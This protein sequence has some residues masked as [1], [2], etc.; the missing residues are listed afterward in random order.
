VGDHCEAGVCQ[1]GFLFCDDKN[2]CT[3]DS[4]DPIKS[5]VYEPLDCNDDNACT[6]DSC[7][8]SEGCANAVDDCDDNNKCTYDF[9]D[10]SLGC[11]YKEKDCE[12]DNDV[13]TIVVCQPQTGKC[14]STSLDCDDQ[15]ACTTESCDPSTG[16][17]SEPLDCD[18]NNDCTVDSC[19]PED[20]CVNAVKGK[21]CSAATDCD[22]DNACTD[23]SCGA[24]GVCENV[25]ISCDDNNECTAASCDPTKG[26]QSV[27][28]E[29]QAC[30]P[31]DPC[32]PVGTCSG[33]GVCAPTENNCPAGTQDDPA[34]SCLQLK[35]SGKGSASGV[36][37]L[38]V[39]PADDQPFQVYCDM[40]TAGGGWARVAVVKSD[41]PICSYAEGYGDP[42]HLLNGGPSTSIMPLAISSLISFTKKELM[43]RRFNG[44]VVFSSAHSLWAWKPVANGTI[45]SDTV[46]NF[47]VSYSHNGGPKGSLAPAKFPGLKGPLLLMGLNV[48]GTMTPSL[49]VGA[50][51]SG[52][53]VQNDACITSGGFNTGL[54]GGNMLPSPI[55]GR[56]GDVFVR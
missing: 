23:D 22:D 48:G 3:A 1:A 17:G 51:Y 14:L 37:W 5:C 36:Y 54:L 18:D 7:D 4:C 30:D 20:G 11:L 42:E 26:C 15:D 43:V 49:G 9:C 41:I 13:C 39:G 52:T 2:L 56:K 53:F 6:V 12:D 27:A 28:L 21:A 46:E 34:L 16:C 8:P 10:E 44:H 24:C 47:G 35:E 45:N 40:D 32:F 19:N 50:A 29:G 38:K 31:G 55:W 25:A 33:K